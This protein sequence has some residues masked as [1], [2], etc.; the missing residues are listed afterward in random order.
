MAAVQCQEAFRG[1]PVRGKAGDPDDGL[2]AERAAIEALDGSFDAEDLA[3][4]REREVPGE[5]NARP[6]PALLDPAVALVGRGALGG[7][8]P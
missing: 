1:R 5:F 8:G 2:V 7:K 3:S 4:M 6:D